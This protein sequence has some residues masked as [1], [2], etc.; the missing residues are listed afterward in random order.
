MRRSMI[1]TALLDLEPIE[2]GRLDTAPQDLGGAV[3]TA[4]C[5][6]VPVKHLNQYV[7]T[8]EWLASLPGDREPGWLR[9]YALT[10]V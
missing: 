4:A 1:F 2:F 9:R 7:G 5:E 3:V 6:G 10:L 8:R